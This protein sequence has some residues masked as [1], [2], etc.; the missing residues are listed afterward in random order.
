MYAIILE[1]IEQFVQRA[2]PFKIWVVFQ[3]KT[4]SSPL[5][6]YIRDAFIPFTRQPPFVSAD[7]KLDN[8][9]IAETC[10]IV[11]LQLLLNLTE[12]NAFCFLLITCKCIYPCSAPAIGTNIA[13]LDNVFDNISNVWIPI[14]NGLSRPRDLLADKSLLSN[15]FVCF[16]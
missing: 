6:S 4:L 2:A 16:L 1:L 11:I 14:N 8:R 3:R 15:L 9:P 5:I 13:L 7:T 10:T 12:C